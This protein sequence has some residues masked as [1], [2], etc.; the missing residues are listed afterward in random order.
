MKGSALVIGP[1]RPWC[2]FDIVMYNT[3]CG[4][5]FFHKSTS[6]QDTDFPLLSVSKFKLILLFD[7]IIRATYLDSIYK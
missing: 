5:L 2:A 6:F 7:W 4:I 3:A 1:F